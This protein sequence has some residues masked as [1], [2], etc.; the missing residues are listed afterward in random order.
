[1]DWKA[2]GKFFS[3]LDIADGISYIYTFLKLLS[4]LENM[5]KEFL[6]NFYFGGFFC[7]VFESGTALSKVGVATIQ[8]MPWYGWRKFFLSKNPKIQKSFLGMIFIKKQNYECKFKKYV[9]IWYVETQLAIEM[10]KCKSLCVWQEFFFQLIE[11]CK[12]GFSRMISFKK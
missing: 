11:R 5:Q 10:H 4:S 2:L 12:K 6:K 7:N 9:P 8:I 3:S 1:M